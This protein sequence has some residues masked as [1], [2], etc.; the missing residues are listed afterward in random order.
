MNRYLLAGLGIIVFG[1]GT[2]TLL[3]ETE[4]VFKD[5]TD[6]SGFSAEEETANTIP[7][8]SE[9]ISEPTTERNKNTGVSGFKIFMS[10]VKYN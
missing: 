6:G 3:A 2:V 4:V 9:I 7:D 8:T 5:N 1:M 10:M